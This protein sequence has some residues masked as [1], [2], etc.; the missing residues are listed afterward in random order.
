MKCED[1]QKELK[2]FLDNDIDDQ[3]KAEIQEHLDGCPNCSKDLEQ[4]KKLSEALHTWKGIEPS[5]HLYEKLKSR[6][7]PMNRSGEKFSHTFP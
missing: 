6:S 3:K 4:L 1:I 7:N 2:A 5:S